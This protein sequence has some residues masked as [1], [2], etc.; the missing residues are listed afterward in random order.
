MDS[1]PPAV[2]VAPLWRSARLLWVML[3]WLLVV[4]GRGLCL[5][6]QRVPPLVWL[7]RAVAAE[8]EARRSARAA[9]ARY[10]GARDLPPPSEAGCPWLQHGARSTGATAHRVEDLEHSVG[11]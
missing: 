1:P 10:Q 9:R 7:V 6:A 11:R 4:L 2:A 8:L 3:P 5:V